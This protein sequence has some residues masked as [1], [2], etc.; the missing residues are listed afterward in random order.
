MFD[1]W[2]SI[3]GSVGRI[4]LA[5]TAATVVAGSP[6]AAQSTPEKTASAS[7]KPVTFNKDIAPILQRSCQQCHRPD[8]IAPMSL[9]TYQEARPYAREIKRRTALRD[10]Y[11]QRGVMPP[12]FVEKNIG[13]QKFKEDI[14]L[15]DQE[16]AK[17]AK[18]ADSGAPEGDAKD[19]PPALQFADASKWAFG[20]PDLIVSSPDVLVKGVAADWWGDFGES[21]T[22][23]KEDRYAR[24]VEY[25]EVSDLKKGVLPKNAGTET[26]AGLGKFGLVV[27][28]H[29]SASVKRQN[30]DLGASDPEAGVGGN[31]SLHEV[32][33]NGD[34]F[35]P[36]SGKIVN[37]NSSLVFNAHI[38][39]P[40][41]PGAD[42]NAHLDVG[43]WFHPQGYKP[44]YREG[45]IQL[46]S[47]ELDIRPDSDYQR[48]DGYW[49]ASQPVR[50]LNYEPH[51][52]ATGMRMCIEA[53]YAKS[54]ETLNC[55]G[56]DHNWVRNYQYDENVAPL[57]PKGTI[58]HLIGWFDGT[59]KNSNNIEPRN[60]TVWGR[61]SVANMF[62]TEN[63]AF[64]LTDEQYKE[65][66]A[67]RKAYYESTG[68]PILGC[69]ACYEKSAP[70]APAPAAPAAR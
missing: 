43:L 53:I 62:G 49:V 42:R 55:A 65:E 7:D 25:K 30:D 57:L 12:W 56:Y 36:E 52:H 66:V 39:A 17:I 37:A 11:G 9:L 20:K 60:T 32:G 29:A 5:V 69:P 54:V 38:H 23:M 28:H 70:A 67:K 3:P 33:R 59:A 40:G 16:V 51:M 24:A 48:F 1:R 50:L 8:S 45:S 58:L 27:F 14:S 2:Q 35:P 26:Y 63:R 34:K 15:S 21:P 6:A 31:L 68:E 46:G 61:R 19:L 4:L 64:F 47:T 44:K 18:W 13:L 22:G 10:T 41:V